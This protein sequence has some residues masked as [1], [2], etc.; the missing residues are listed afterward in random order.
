MSPAQALFPPVL[1]VFTLPH[2]AVGLHL[3][4]HC[5]SVARSVQL[6]ATTMDCSTPGFPVLHYLREF[7]QT[8]VH[9]VDKAIQ[10]SHPLLPSSPPAPN[11]S[12]LQGL[13]QWVGSLHQ[14]AEVLELQHPTL[15]VNIQC[16]FPLGL[17]GLM[18][19]LSKRLSRVFS[20]TT[21]WKHQFFSAQG[22]IGWLLHYLWL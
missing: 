15:P 18:S 1:K 16:W 5:C 2:I 11:L 19:L 17:T 20:S 14:V 13:F 4:P 12:Q 8:H 6:F 22:L 3:G 7:A 9:Q 10:P 21:I